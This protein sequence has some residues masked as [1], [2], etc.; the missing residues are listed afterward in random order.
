MEVKCL[1]EIKKQNLNNFYNAM[2][3]FTAYTADTQWIAALQWRCGVFT[4]LGLAAI[5]TMV[6]SAGYKKYL[7]ISAP[8]VGHIIS[9]LLSTGWSEFRY[10][11]PLNLMNLFLLL[12]M[13]LV[14]N[15][16]SGE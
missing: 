4:L 8:I 7:L 6:W 10:F 14:L 16:N 15:G 3:R 11:W 13:I 1:M 2:G 12:F 9:L 5:L